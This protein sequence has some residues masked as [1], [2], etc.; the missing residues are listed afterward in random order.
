MAKHNEIGKA[1]EQLSVDYLIKKGYSVIERNWIHGKLEIDII[2]IYKGQIVFI[3][4][5]TRTDDWF[6]EPKDAVNKKKIRNIVRA[7]DA[8][9]KINSIDLEPRF[10]IVDI[11]GDIGYMKIEHI[12]DAFVPP[13]M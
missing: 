13:L 5:K 4:V 12:E 9:I 11:V 7:A 8:Y 3:E 10:D 6:A 2:A 1:G